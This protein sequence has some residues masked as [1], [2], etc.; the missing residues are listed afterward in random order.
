MKARLGYIMPDISDEGV[1]SP[2]YAAG[3]SE[4]FG[5]YDPGYIEPAPEIVVR[6]EIE[7]VLTLDSGTSP[8]LQTTTVSPLP[9][10]SIP[11]PTSA[12]LPVV[13]DLSETDLPTTVPIVQAGSDTGQ[14]GFNWWWLLLLAGG[15]YMLSKKRSVK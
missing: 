15:L 6:P 11:L 12:P 3:D 13:P 5:G 8:I 1:I 2:Y 9:V 14:T 10:Q 4:Y 7:Q